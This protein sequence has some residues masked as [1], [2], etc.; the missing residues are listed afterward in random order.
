MRMSLVAIGIA[1]LFRML[2]VLVLPAILVSRL[3]RRLGASDA[4]PWGRFALRR[5]GVVSLVTVA[6][7]APWSLRSAIGAP[8]LFLQGL[9]CLD[10]PLR[11]HRLEETAG[12]VR[13]GKGELR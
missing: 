10:V 13:A 7:L 5:L 12:L 8:P 4:T 1:G 6:V 3:L 11:E 2:D 9:D